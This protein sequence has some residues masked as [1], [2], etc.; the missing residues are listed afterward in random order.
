VDGYMV[1]FNHHGH[2]PDRESVTCHGC[3]DVYRS[4]LTSESVDHVAGGPEWR[5]VTAPRPRANR[6][7]RA[8]PRGL[9]GARDGTR[10]RTP[11]RQLLLRQS[12]LPF[13]HPGSRGC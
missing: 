13:H 5:Q 8:C 7:H 6:H 12:C 9:G 10:T 3:G 4:A 2:S 1:V 11:F